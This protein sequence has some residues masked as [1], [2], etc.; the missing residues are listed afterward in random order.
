MFYLIYSNGICF[1]IFSLLLHRFQHH[2]VTFFKKKI[3][4]I[5]KKFKPIVKNKSKLYTINWLYFVF[6]LQKLYK[7]DTVIRVLYIIIFLVV[8][9]YLNYSCFFFWEIHTFRTFLLKHS[10]NGTN[11]FYTLLLY[12]SLLSPSSSSLLLL[13]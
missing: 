8:L 10:G 4:K 6:F 11:L 5:I 7:Q 12:L 13:N 1:W 2:T 3:D 9:L